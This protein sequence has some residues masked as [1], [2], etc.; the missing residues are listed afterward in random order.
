MLWV[1]V[2]AIFLTLLRDLDMETVWIV[3]G[4]SLFMVVMLV[5]SL[6]WFGFLGFF[7]FTVFDWLIAGLK[8]AWS[9]L[10]SKQ[11]PFGAQ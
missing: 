8:R 6:F 9:W 7:L 5:T 2:A 1:V 10:D 3:M 11:G 4:V